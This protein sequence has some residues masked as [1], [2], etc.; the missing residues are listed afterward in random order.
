MGASDVLKVLQIARDEGQCDFKTSRVTINHGMH[1]QVHTI[2]HS[3]YTQ[4]L[5]SIATSVLYSVTSSYLCIRHGPI[6]NAMFC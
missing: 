6:R 2:F 4:V 3:L 5:V 1:D